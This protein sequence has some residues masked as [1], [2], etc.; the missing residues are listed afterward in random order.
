MVIDSD[1]QS[2]LE[3][4]G[5]KR[6]PL[7]LYIHIPFCIHKCHYCDFNSHV[8]DEPPWHAYQQAL[9][10]ELEYWSQQDPFHGR[11]LHSIFFGGGTPSLAPAS[12]IADVLA[13]AKSLF[14]FEENIEISLEAN[15]GT[16]DMQA[17]QGFYD[18]GINRLSIGAQSLDHKE[19]Q[20]L[21]RIHNND[22]VYKAIAAARSA[23]FDNINLDLMYGLPDQTVQQWQ[24]TLAAALSLNPE[25]LSCY[26]LTVE[27]HTKLA[28]RHA[29]SPYALPDDAASLQFFHQTRQDLSA[30]AYTAYEISNFSK[31]G[32]YCRHN[33]GYW[34]YHDYIGIGAG[35]SGKWDKHDGGTYRYS[36]HRMPE[37]YIQKST[38]GWHAISSDESLNQQ[39]AAAEAVWVGLRRK[40]GMDDDWFSQ[41][42]DR[43]IASYFQGELQPWLDD[44]KLIWND[45]RLQ[46]SGSGIVLADAIAGSVIQ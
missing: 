13:Y 38:A 18:A 10:C 14:G 37:K 33:D 4:K 20:W 24:Q 35:A 29:S 8:R 12:L 41:R 3:F 15:P 6:S 17:F 44:E 11:S 45:R 9:I 23:G 25:H 1:I 7:Q 16:V 27:P 22:D 2:A 30:A 19:L 40:E 21:E 32:K 46:L 5:F 34:L 26:Q 43:P 28:V 39:Q 36:N 31:A 42:F